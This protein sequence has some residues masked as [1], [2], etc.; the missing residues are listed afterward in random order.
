MPGIAPKVT[1]LKDGSSNYYFIKTK[2]K[3]ILIDAP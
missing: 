2:E 1:F 3:E